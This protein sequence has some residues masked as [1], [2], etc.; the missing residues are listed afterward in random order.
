MP[1]TQEIE[2]E[3]G[4]EAVVEARPPAQPVRVYALP[5]F[6]V[7]KA[8]HRA[9]MLEYLEAL[10]AAT[11]LNS[12]SEKFWATWRR[13]SR[14]WVGSHIRARLLLLGNRYAQL[15]QVCTPEEHEMRKW[16]KDEREAGAE[17]AD[18]LYSLRLPGLFVLLPLS[19]TLIA[20]I[21]KVPG[22][23]ITLALAASAGYLLGLPFIVI[24]TFRQK[25]ELL[26]PGARDVEL[27]KRP[28]DSTG[29][30]AFRAETELFELLEPSGRHR[31]FPTDQAVQSFFLI[32]LL[33][34]GCGV[35]LEV[36]GIGPSTP[37][38]PLVLFLAGG[39]G[40]LLVKPLFRQYERR[41]WR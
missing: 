17:F 32:T 23:V 31:E 5:D 19:V 24:S 35:L 28:D 13:A 25:R 3:V 11:A 7:L 34:V 39:V 27:R 30:N 37:I 40:S 20:A 8:R 33:I 36:L 14:M 4:E 16:L 21:A 41:S 6:E 9:L 15:H 2:T 18:S 26:F 38:A 1:D 29:R 12:D 22:L 10:D